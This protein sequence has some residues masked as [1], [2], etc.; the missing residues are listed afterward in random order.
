MMKTIE[1]MDFSWRNHNYVEIKQIE[2]IYFRF[3]AVFD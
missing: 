1:I 2:S 3:L